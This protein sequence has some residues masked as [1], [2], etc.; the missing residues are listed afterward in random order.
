MKEKSTILLSRGF[1]MMEILFVIVI[2]GILASIAVPRLVANKQ[3]A[4]ISQLKSQITTIREGIRDYANQQRLA[5]KVKKKIFIQ[6]S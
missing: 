5:K 1:T 2:L 3:D 6:S 4:Q